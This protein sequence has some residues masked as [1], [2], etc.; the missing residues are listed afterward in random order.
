MFDDQMQ[1]EYIR[2]VLEPANKADG[3]HATVS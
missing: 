1:E 2:Y 3:M